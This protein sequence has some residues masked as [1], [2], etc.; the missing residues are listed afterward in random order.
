[1]AQ[2][3]EEYKWG[4]LYIVAMLFLVT[5]FIGY[6]AYTYDINNGEVTMNKKIY[7]IIDDECDEHPTT[8]VYPTC[9]LCRESAEKEVNM[10]ESY[11]DAY[12]HIYSIEE[13]ELKSE[14]E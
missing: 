14:E 5:L 8:G 9:F 12:L 4:V 11:H 7:V 3:D 13:I 10:L 6:K 1:M 2:N